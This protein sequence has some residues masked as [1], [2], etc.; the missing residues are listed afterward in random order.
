[1]FPGTLKGAAMITVD[2][3]RHGRV[4]VA[5][6]TTLLE[7]K[8][9]VKVPEKPLVPVVGALYNNRLM[10]LEYLL[11]RN[12]T[13]RFLTTRHEEGLNIYSKSLSIL[14]HAAFIDCGPKNALLKVEH[15]LNKGFF[16]SYI[17]GTPLAEETVR[18][19]NKRMREIV[20]EDLPFEKC[21]YEVE[22]ALDLL[23][24]IGAWDRYYLLKYS[25]RS[26]TTIYRLGECV[27]LAQGPVVPSAGY[28]KIF[29]LRYYPP[30]LVLLFPETT[31]PTKLPEAAEQKKLFQIYS[32]Q[33]EWSRI[34]D[35]DSAGKLNRL[36]IK[37]KIDNLVWVTEGLHE[38]KIAQIADIITKNSSKRRII[39]LAGPT[40]SGKTTFAK[41]LTVQL[42]ANG[43]APEVISL[44]NY[45]LPR[46]RMPKTKA[47]TI[48]LE[49]LHSLDIDLINTHLNTLIDGNA[50]TIPKYE[51]KTGSRQQEGRRVKLMENQVVIIEGIHALNEKLTPYIDREQKYKIYVS[52]LTQ[53][54]IDVINR[55]PTS[56]VRLLRRIVR[57]S[58]FRG[59]SARETIGLWPEVRRAEDRNIFP[60][61]EEAD[62]MFN[63]SLVYEM[64]VLKGYAQPLLKDIDEDDKLYTVA[65]RLLHFLDNFLY[66]TSEKV[67]RTSILREFIGE[68]GF[69]Y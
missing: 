53:L 40:S 67:P 46:E 34:L 51:F 36:I 20:E 12:C 33:R 61:G 32:E 13:V 28:L 63:S 26:K 57:D 4:E 59:Y 64:S 49:S 68:S 42:L 23:E 11:T 5:E 3:Y 35:V 17:D 66:I 21:E 62:V 58:Q 27:N 45:Y 15:S 16:F 30:G 47:G 14:L 6:K 41:R 48:D 43:I 55:V 39:L 69:S 10:G 24:E 9:L 2:I 1:M 56:T 38:K 7:L 54:N 19:L 50:V 31:D 44:D 52:V 37:R 65:K 8:R 29:G 22:D 60:F 18:R 25:D